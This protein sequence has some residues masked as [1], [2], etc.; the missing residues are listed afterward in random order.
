LALL[1][2]ASLVRATTVRPTSVE[3]LAHS[4]SLIVEARA[5]DSWAQWN[6]EHTIIF[7]YTKF[8][9]VRVLKGDAT[10]RIVV[11]QPGGEAPPYAQRIPGVRPFQAG[12]DALLFLLP[13]PSGD[14][15]LIVAGLLQGNFRVYR[16]PGGEM[17]S[18]ND[19]AGVE[20]IQ[21]DGSLHGFHGTNLPLAELESRIRKALTQ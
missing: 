18:S 3:R 11:K 17:W 21:H 1:V 12:E 4:A 20:E 5:Q 16:T 19:V 9:V 7:T 15:T 8:Q 13:S 14:G 10:Q 6:P 2:L